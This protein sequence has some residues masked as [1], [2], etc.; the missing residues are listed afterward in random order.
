MIAG[1]SITD[2]QTVI[3]LRGTLIRSSCRQLKRWRQL[4]I[5]WDGAS[6]APGHCRSSSPPLVG[7]KITRD[8]FQIKTGHRIPPKP[9]TW[10]KSGQYPLMAVAGVSVAT[11]TE[12]K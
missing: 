5:R 6:L 12:Q 9:A 1:R 10:L 11:P 8:S 2:R 3:S 4:V 7:A